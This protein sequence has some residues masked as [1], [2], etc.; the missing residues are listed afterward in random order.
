[1]EVTAGV[2]LAAAGTLLFFDKL[3]FWG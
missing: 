2:I 1:V 3:M